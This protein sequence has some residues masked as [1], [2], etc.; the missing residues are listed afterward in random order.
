VNEIVCRRAE[1]ADLAA[2]LQI[3]EFAQVSTRRADDLAIALSAKEV[4][5]A[6]DGDEVVGYLVFDHSFFG[7]GFVSVIVVAQ[8][9]R[10]HGVGLHLL[11]EAGRRCRT[12]KLFT[13]TSSSNV[14]AAN[15]F[16]RAGFVRSGVIENLEPGDPEL[17]Y[18]K[19]VEQPE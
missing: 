10:R 7:N 17:V 3:D 19:R 4:I 12:S 1:R 5:V 18:F 8:E 2:M 13:S 14:A 11:H 16:E 6:Q 15:L 9:Q